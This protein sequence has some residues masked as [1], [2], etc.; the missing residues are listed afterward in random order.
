MGGAPAAPSYPPAGPP[1]YDPGPPPLAPGP[2][3][4]EPPPPAP[5]R[6]TNWLAI[7]VLVGLVAVIGIGIWL[8]RDRLTSNV[9]DLAVGDCFDR[10]TATDTITDVQHQPC[11]GAHDRE[12]I[13]VLTHPAGP[14][15]A[16]PVVSGFGDYVQQN[17]VPAFE[18]YTGRDADTE[19]ELDL[20][21]FQP[22]LAG[23]GD[24]DRGFTCFVSR[25]D[26]QRLNGS[27]RGIGSSPLP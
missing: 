25:A 20:G 15:D 7:I 11:N 23:W 1:S 4:Y 13:A 19:S 6:K 24:G 18:S 10:P 5:R 9:T 16:Y 2:T 14:N 17:C 3:A 21:Y 8:F 27:L 26:G 22:T 12:V